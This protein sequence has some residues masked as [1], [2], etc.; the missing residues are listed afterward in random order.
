MGRGR[1]E[2]P[3]KGPGSRC[4][5]RGTILTIDGE[6][7][8]QP[9]LLD[10][11]GVA[12]ADLPLGLLRHVSGGPLLPR[13]EANA[14]HE[15]APRFVCGHSDRARGVYAAPRA[16]RSLRERLRA[17][18]SLAYARLVRRPQPGDRRHRVEH[19]SNR[20]DRRADHR[21]RMH[22][23][24]LASLHARG[25]ATRCRTGP[26][27]RC[28]RSVASAALSHSCRLSHGTI[29]VRVTSFASH[30]RVLQP[31]ARGNARAR[32]GQRLLQRARQR[33]PPRHGRAPQSQAP[34]DNA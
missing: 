33:V 19:R 30:L 18:A 32:P 28:A 17:A 26:C 11:D 2:P 5:P 15:D 31:A 1:S 27:R 10:S 14:P 6:H 7:Y 25:S 8:D 4:M 21:H 16:R 22:G 13:D 3:G 12:H 29:P 34:Q 24:V 20:A 23:V 9:H